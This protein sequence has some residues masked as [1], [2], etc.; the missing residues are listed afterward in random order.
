MREAPAL[1]IINELVK[2]GVLIRACDPAAIPEATWRLK[3]M[4]H[5]VSF[6]DDEY[7]AIKGSNAL[8]IMT[9]WN[10]YR[11]LD[12]ERVKQL[13]VEPLFF[14]LRNVYTRSDMEQKGF[15]YFAIG[16]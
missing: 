11:N 2:K 6:F 16:Q 15:Q 1:V 5:A 13:L 4:E 8:V 7:E 14:D 10:Q 3:A 12:L 9:E